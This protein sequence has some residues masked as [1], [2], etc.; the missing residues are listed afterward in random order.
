MYLETEKLLGKIP[1]KDELKEVAKIVKKLTE[2][3]DEKLYFEKWER[4]KWFRE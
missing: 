3:I 1:R 4:F 2:E